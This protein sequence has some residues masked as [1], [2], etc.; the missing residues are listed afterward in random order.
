MSVAI[1]QIFLR[2]KPYNIFTSY[3]NTKSPPHLVNTSTFYVLL[4]HT[5]HPM[6]IIILC[7]KY[8]T[9][10][11][12][13]MATSRN[14]VALGKKRLI[15]KTNCKEEEKANYEMFSY[16]PPRKNTFFNRTEYN[17]PP[18]SRIPAQNLSKL[19]KWNS[20]SIAV[21]I[22]P[23]LFFN[24]VPVLALAWR[25]GKRETFVWKRNKLTGLKALYR[26]K[27][28]LVLIIFHS[29]FGVMK[30]CKRIS[31]IGHEASPIFIPF[32]G[33]SEDEISRLEELSGK[34]KNSACAV[35]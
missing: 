31:P 10:K 18:F 20:F 8:F 5:H 1:I 22:R 23:M 12:T 17:A 29:F 13:S 34:A 21:L 28:P 15:L 27:H 14:E 6:Q 16:F 35:R 26:S 33:F 11:N 25:T 24:F 2:K 19:V 9:E 32:R 30:D 3:I 4:P 7:L